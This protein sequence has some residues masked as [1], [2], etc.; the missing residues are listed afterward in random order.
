MPKVSVNQK[1]IKLFK[2]LCNKT[3][4]YKVK[5]TKSD[6]GATILDAGIKAK[7]SIKA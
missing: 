2:D 6:L 4:Y 1:A 3:N 7:G 5:V